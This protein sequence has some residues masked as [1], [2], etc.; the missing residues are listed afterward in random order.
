[1]AWRF[2]FANA[3][4]FIKDLG[5]NKRHR[6]VIPRRSGHLARIMID[7]RPNTFLFGSEL[8]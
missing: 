6:Y 1:L 5:L 3:S 8:E 2:N 4:R 7:A